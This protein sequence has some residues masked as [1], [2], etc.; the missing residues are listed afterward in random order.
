MSLE[1]ESFVVA[2]SLSVSLSHF[3]FVSTC[4]YP[5]ERYLSRAMSDNA[6]SGFLKARKCWP[7][8]G[9]DDL[10]P[11]TARPVYDSWMSASADD[12]LEA[13]AAA[14][15]EGL[16]RLPGKDS[17]RAQ[18]RDLTL[19][20]SPLPQ[21][22]SAVSPLTTAQI[23]SLGVVPSSGRPRRSRGNS[24][25]PVPAEPAFPA[26]RSRSVT[27]VAPSSDTERPTSPVESVAS[28]RSSSRGAN[29]P[30]RDP[31]SPAASGRSL[32]SPGATAKRVAELE[33][34]LVEQNER[35]QQLF[36]Q[37]LAEPHEDVSSAYKVLD[38]VWHKLGKL[39]SEDKC[40]WLQ[41]T[42]LKKREISEIVRTQSGTYPFFPCE[43]DVIGGMKKLPGVKDAQISL[44]DFAQTEVTKFMRSN[45]RTVRLS[46]TVF[47]RALEM[48]QDLEDFIDTNPH[49]T[50]IPLEMVVEFVD[51][52][53]DAARGTF[54]ISIDTQTT[55]RLAVSQ[56][57]EKAMKVDHLTT[58]NPLK[59]EREDF[60]PPS[61]M[62]R[63]EDAAKRNLDLSWALDQSNGKASFSGRRPENSSRG[64]KKEYA[65]QR[66]R[67][68][69]SSKPGGGKGA[70][71]SGS[72]KGG[73]GRGRGGG[74][75]P[76]ADTRV[77]PVSPE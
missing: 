71:G 63:I 34:L 65:R 57:L 43:L 23:V 42:A 48:Q 33:R 47:S 1:K 15:S 39:P 19:F 58:T 49:A 45:T 12:R 29:G 8:R 68:G 76:R 61:A 6:L 56:R 11:D 69:D 14:L 10:I 5:G 46:G 73:K 13:L 37:Q 38:E 41:V 16:T 7:E 40:S 51:K 18:C 36:A 21:A 9:K 59:A 3:S 32:G 62:R 70:R 50:E 60:I 77:D 75:A 17:S 64:G 74:T 27:R 54:A 53:V 2:L 31:P 26:R 22:Q 35:I 44:L 24:A 30:V 52:M 28:S 67:G 20:G 72:S 66:N 4:V 55:L 25:P